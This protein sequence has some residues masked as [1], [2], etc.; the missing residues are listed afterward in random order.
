[1]ITK[2][3]GNCGKT[4]TKQICWCNGYHFI[5]WRGSKLGKGILCG[6]C[7]RKEARSIGF[8]IASY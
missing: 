3:C 7:V 5:G 1:M 6:E 2:T 4:E 8:P